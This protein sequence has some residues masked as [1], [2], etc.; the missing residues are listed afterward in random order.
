MAKKGGAGGGRGGGRGVKIVGR[1]PPPP[2]WRKTPAAT[3]K[4]ERANS[5]GDPP[6][7]ASPS[8]SSLPPRSSPR[9]P[10][11]PIGWRRRGAP[12]GAPGTGRPRSRGGRAPASSSS[13]PP[14]SRQPSPPGGRG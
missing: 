5:I 11:P 14:P 4:R 2:P 1:G 7:P 10:M 3:L 12:S 13:P 8:I 9:P 6:C